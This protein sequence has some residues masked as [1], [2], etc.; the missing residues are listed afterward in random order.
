VK[1]RHTPDDAYEM[2]GNTGSLRYMAPEVALRKP[3]NEKADVYSF[4][5]LLWQMAQDRVPFKGMNREEFMKFVV[6]GGERPKLDKSWP[7]P[8]SNMLASCWHQDHLKR[9]SF[10]ELSHLLSSLTSD[11]N[12]K[13]KSSWGVTLSAL[14]PSSSPGDNKSFKF[15]TSP[16]PQNNATTAASISNNSPNTNNTAATTPA[17]QGSPSKKISTWF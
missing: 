11:L 10:A 14:P 4:G 3:Y 9:P 8:F 2:T 13:P 5:I 6:I 17:T 7:S 15:G 1:A 16:L 12:N